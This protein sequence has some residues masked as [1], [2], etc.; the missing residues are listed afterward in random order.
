M[1]QKGLFGL[2]L[3]GF[4]LLLEYNDRLDYRYRT[5]WK[6]GSEFSLLEMLYA[7]I[8]YYHFTLNFHYETSRDKLPDFTYGLG[9]RLPFAELLKNKVPL[10]LQ[11]DIA[12]LPQLSYVT[13]L[14]DGESFTAWSLRINWRL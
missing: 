14:D 10:T 5:G 12:H 4:S 8:G 1:R 6:M 9:F 7:R 2:Y 13:D 11:V 3:V